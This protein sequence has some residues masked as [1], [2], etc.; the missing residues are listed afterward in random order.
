MIECLF[1][2]VESRKRR[3]QTRMNIQNSPAKILEK[4][5]RQ[6]AHVTCKTNQVNFLSFQLGHD[7]A[8]MFCPRAPARSMTRVSIPRSRAFVRPAAMADR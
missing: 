2:R 5:V 1:L 8:V 6:D 7:F 3:Q 4:F